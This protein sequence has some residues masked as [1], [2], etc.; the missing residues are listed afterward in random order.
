MM[1]AKKADLLVPAYDSRD[2]TWSKGVAGN[3]IAVVEASDLNRR[4]VS[5]QVWRDSCDVGF[6]VVSHRTGTEKLFVFS[7]EIKDAEGEVIASV[8]ESVDGSDID[9]HVMND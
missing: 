2:F 6:T 3:S 4:Q 8:Y 9:I 5:A 7:R 1:V